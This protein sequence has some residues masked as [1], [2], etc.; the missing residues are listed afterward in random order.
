[1]A[2]S[3]TIIERYVLDDR[4][5]GP[6]TRITSVTMGLAGAARLAATAM[7]GLV[8]AGAI[9]LIGAGIA[10]SMA[11]AKLESLKNMLRSVVGSAEE[12]EAA[13]D[14]LQAVAVLPAMGTENAVRGFA[15][16]FEVTKDAK[17]ATDALVEFSNAVA[18]SGGGTEEMSRMLQNLIQNVGLTRLMGDE[19]REIA[20]I[21]PTF[22][23][24][25]KEAFGTND[26]QE[27]AKSGMTVKQVFE[28]VIA[29]FSKLERVN[30][31]A[32]T[33]FARLKNAAFMFLA[34][35][36][37]ELNKFLVPAI[38]QLSSALTQIAQ[39]GVIQRIAADFVRLAGDGQQFG[40]RIVTGVF[41]AIA[42]VR[43]LPSFVDLAVKQIGLH[44]NSMRSGFLKVA[45]AIGG[46]LL[47]GPIVKGVVGLIGFI[48]RF[49]VAIREMTT[50]W[51][52]FEAIVSGGT[53]LTKLALG[54]LAATA[55]TAVIHAA[56]EKMV[57]SASTTGLQIPGMSALEDAIREGKDAAD[58]FYGGA[59][60]MDAG[61]SLGGGGSAPTIE[62]GAGALIDS[63]A[64][65]AGAVERNTEANDRLGEINRMI[66][67]GG[68][69]GRFG[70]S[71]VE[72]GQNRRGN[73]TININGGEDAHDAIMRLK[74]L[75]VLG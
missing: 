32:A 26:L 73:V 41:V 42:V 63:N 62:Y 71:P 21:V 57:G 1:M 65:L 8:G 54:L 20:S 29:Q 11:G 49:V 19:L 27:I 28:G 56:F 18:R 35:A 30:G 70:V 22:R 25:L 23:T 16:L 68:N 58:R 64:R 24:A 51:S 38:E 31:G 14:R 50:A 5:S 17:F 37:T 48:G 40:R 13:F 36:G 74:R 67:G 6:A 44:F 43:R 53:S 60:A 45:A 9:G 12:A 52:V 33:A 15:A 69:L 66:F 55:A 10:A 7:A 4:Y 61:G 39:S 59:M 2:G 46:F 3:N 72:L 75:G 34:T 47:A